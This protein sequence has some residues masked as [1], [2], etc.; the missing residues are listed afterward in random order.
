[1]CGNPGFEV[2]RTCWS[3][4]IAS[5]SARSRLRRASSARNRTKAVGSVGNFV[6]VRA[7]WERRTISMAR[8]KAVEKLEDV[9]NAASGTMLDRFAAGLR[10]D[11]DA[12]NA[13]LQ[14][15]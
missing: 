12:I 14:L 8:R 13:A 10:R 6:W 11:F 5:N 1:M 15:P 2:F 3:A 4:M 9:L 7:C